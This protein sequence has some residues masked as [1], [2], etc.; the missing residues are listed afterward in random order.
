ML[1]GSQNRR[2]SLLTNCPNYVET[3]H[4]IE[5]IDYDDELPWPQSADGGGDSLH[6][7]NVNTYGRDSSNWAAAAPDPGN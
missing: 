7:V 1:T 3:V 6:R 4:P 5:K 2:K